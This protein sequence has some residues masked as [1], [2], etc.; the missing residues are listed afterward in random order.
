MVCAEI[1]VSPPRPTAAEIMIGSSLPSSSKTSR[2][3]TSAALALSESKMVSTSSTSE[4]PAISARICCDVRD[5]HLI[6]RAHA[7]AGVVGVG[8]VRERHG[9]RPDRARHEARPPIRVRHAIGPLATL[10]RR[11]LVDLPGEIVEKLVVDDLLV[12]LRIL[13]AAVLARIVDEEL[14]LRDA[15]GAEGVGLDDVRAGLEKAPVDVADHLRL[16][17]REEIA[18]VQQILLRVLEALAADVGLVHAVGADGRAHRA[19]D[20]GDAVLEQLLERMRVRHG[21]DCQAQLVLLGALGGLEA[22]RRWPAPLA[23]WGFLA[24]RQATSQRA[25]VEARAATA[26]PRSARGEKPGWRSP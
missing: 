14:A 22:C 3:A 12:K 18:V 11:L 8:R 5:L 13:A 9:E 10:P 24:S 15:G 6:E 16:R 1:I 20:D 4:P 23:R 17:E 25:D 21:R 7:E 26:E 2:M 19:V